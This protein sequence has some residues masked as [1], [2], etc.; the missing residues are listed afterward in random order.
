MLNCPVPP[1]SSRRPPRRCSGPPVHGI[2]ELNH[3]VRK[4]YVRIVRRTN[5]NGRQFR[6]HI[7]WKSRG[8]RRERNRRR[9]RLHYGDHQVALRRTVF[10]I[11]GIICDEQ[12]PPSRVPRHHNGRVAV[13]QGH[14]AEGRQA[15]RIAL[16]DIHQKI[17]GAR[18][19]RA[20]FFRTHGYGVTHR[21]SNRNHRRRL[22]QRHL[23]R[24]PA[25]WL[26]SQSV[27]RWITKVRTRS[28]SHPNTTA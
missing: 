20:W 13:D 10:R 18:G 8:R 11:A 25:R 14:W 2:E 9:G 27:K 17:Y 7:G 22:M 23:G 21:L 19:Y 26:H 12:V 4:R 28:S 6:L 24:S 3:S 1:M 15:E 5:N 16:A